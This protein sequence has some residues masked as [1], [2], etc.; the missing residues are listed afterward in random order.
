MDNQKDD[1]IDLTVE[2]T[3]K[4]AKTLNS[5][6]TQSQKAI[7][8]STISAEVK[9]YVTN[10][11]INISL[12]KLFSK[13][14]VSEKMIE[15]TKLLCFEAICLGINAQPNAPKNYKYLDR[16]IEKYPEIANVALK[17]HHNCPKL[18]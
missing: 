6:T 4:L 7:W 12:K 1:D 17:Q 13:V 16:F 15:S 8:T 9:G 14:G 18:Q 3:I 10:K 2:L 5:I 11:N